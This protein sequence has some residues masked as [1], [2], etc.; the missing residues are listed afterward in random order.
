MPSESRARGKL[1]SSP[2]SDSYI[3]L[4]C[5]E[6]KTWNRIVALAKGSALGSARKP[7]APGS[8]EVNTL[9]QSEGAGRREGGELGEGHKG[10]FF[11][12]LILLLLLL[13]ISSVEKKKCLK[14]PN[15]TTVA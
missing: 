8:P 13:A 12:P 9:T 1:N 15:V 4:T 3:F 11:Y 5:T 10:S 2:L 14:G 6:K 7:L